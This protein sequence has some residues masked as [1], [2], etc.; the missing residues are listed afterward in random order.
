[1]RILLIDLPL[2]ARKKTGG[3]LIRLEDIS[4]QIF[5]TR[6]VLPPDFSQTLRL[7]QKT[8]SHTF[9]HRFMLYMVI[10]N[11]HYFLITKCI[12]MFKQLVYSSA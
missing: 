8:I 5:Q 12:C 9:A 1:M 11:Y 7:Y 4:E 3:H 2:I 6:V 10:A